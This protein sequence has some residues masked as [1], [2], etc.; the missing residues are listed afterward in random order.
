MRTRRN[1]KPV[2]PDQLWLFPSLAASQASELDD[3]AAEF[4]PDNEAGPV[5]LPAAVSC[6]RIVTIPPSEPFLATLARALLDGTLP[7]G[8]AERLPQERGPLD[9]SAITLLLPTRRAA[10]GLQEA[11]LAASASRALLLPTIRPIADGDED[12]SLLA[13]LSGAGDVSTLAL[14]LPPAVSE[15]ERRLVLT[16]LVLQWSDAMGRGGSGADAAPGAKTPAQA[17]NLARE[18]SRLID[19]VETEQI[20]LDG[21]ADIVRED[22]S[23]HWQQTLDFLQIVTSWWPAYLD[24]SGLMSA[25]ARR[26]ALILAE[27][28]RLKAM[29]PDG[30]VI[31]AGVTGSIPATVA[32]MRT[33]ANLPNGAIVLPGLDLALDEPSWQAI[34]GSQS[35][36]GSKSESGPNC[37]PH[38]EHP[39]FGLKTLLDRLGLTRA[40]IAV[41]SRADRVSPQAAAR[42]ERARLVSEA[43]RPSATT[44]R[45]LDTIAA[46]D[47]AAARA[48]IDGVTLINA[49]SAQDEAEA[50][51]II[52]REAAETPGRTAALISPDRL[53]ARRVAVRL[54]AWGIRVDDSA[55]RPLRKTPPG[56]LLD[57]TIAAIA[58]DFAPKPLMALL[59]HPLTRL[60]LDPFVVRRSARAIEIGAFRRPYLGRGLTG[61][62]AALD[63]AER[64]CALGPDERTNRRTRAAGRLFKD[65]WAGARDLVTRL[66]L[67]FAPLI[68]L[69]DDGLDHPLA[70]FA[71]AHAATGAALTALPPLAD[72]VMPAGNAAADVDLTA[73]TPWHADDT[74][75]PLWHGEAG[76]VARALLEG[77]TRPGLPAPDLAARDYPDV[78]RAL[79]VTETVRPRVPVHS[80]LSIWGP[81]EARLQQPDIVILGGLNDGTWPDA[82]DPGPWLNRQ[83]RAELG[84]PA[85]EEKL[86]Y[87]AHDFATAMGASRVFLTRAEKI[88]GVPT[89]PSRWLMRL[90]A[91]LG[92]LGLADALRAG[93]PDS[94][95][96]AWAR[97]RDK[98]GPWSPVAK[99]APRPP[100]DVRPRKLS[101]SAV[102]TWIG[103]P[104]AV[105]ASHILRLEPMPALGTAPDASIR[106]AI[107]HEAM[108]KFA[109]AWPDT[110]PPDIHGEL[111]THADAVLRDWT[112]HAR[113]AAFWLP[114]FERF[115]EW[116]AETEPSR[117]IG[118]VCAEVKGELQLLPS[119]SL[120]FTLTARADR[121]DVGDT[122]V[123]ITDYKTGTPPSKSAVNALH[124]PQLPLEGAILAAGGFG[125]V[126]STG[127]RI[128]GTVLG[129]RY[130]KAS[131]GEPAGIETDIK[132]DDLANLIE[133]AAAGLTRL[134]ARFDDPA[135]PYAV[136]RRAKFSYDFDPYTQLARVA[137]W[138]ATGTAEVSSDDAN[139]AGEAT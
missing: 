49:P 97:Q 47:R 7:G 3:A 103:N 137:E 44:G 101:V 30:P 95:Y 135:T 93:V 86:G 63:A 88:D 127:S 76:S 83:M 48:A 72:A 105:F 82:A 110:L 33:V 60:G 34:T 116:F 41:L 2:S 39:Q 22:F 6:D 114:R 132:T 15:L 120:P 89:V 65:D 29:P 80:R 68:A 113:V 85:P 36:S 23:A 96:L 131:G 42:Q 109:M 134:V 112:G 115:A 20:S 81:M 31:V 128:A 52:L 71:H 69:F 13:G 4:F 12:A 70:A 37:P 21:L 102:E 139:D 5:A 17:V 79:I 19:M 107:V 133:R 27:A 55:G 94:T 98:P 78:Y 73:S 123:L 11:F 121:L 10:R 46:T 122:G 77:L 28:E 126:A 25:A 138:S 74:V 90:D 35:I 51:A 92:G 100:I 99:P 38:P 61:I 129:L 53:L 24:G 117:R 124:K 45:W 57:L 130:I 59:K 8:E 87:A 66:E 84:L 118:R 136:A 58:E 119:A 108:A 75:C 91:L 43:L 40:D 26:N 106:G 64:D 104:Y 54:E 16:K 56:A 62:R 18:L 9:L 14:T 111:M 125:A 32:L 67:A 50:V 1:A